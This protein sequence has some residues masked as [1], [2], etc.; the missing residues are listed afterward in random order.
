VRGRV[1]C[2]A[3]VVRDEAAKSGT[4]ER[5]AGMAER[6]S[7]MCAAAMVEDSSLGL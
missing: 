5:L 7:R 2:V 6:D 1:V 4:S 3:Q